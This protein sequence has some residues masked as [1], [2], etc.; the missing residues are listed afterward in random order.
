VSGPLAAVAFMLAL[1]AVE[2]PHRM[3]FATLDN[4]LSVG[5]ALV[6]TTDQQVTGRMDEV[7]LPRSN[8]VSRVLIDRESGAYFGYRLVAG[9]AGGGRVRIAFQSLPRGFDAE[10]KR[11]PPCEGCPALTRLTASDP[12]FPAPQ[13]TADGETVRLELLANPRSGERIIDVV[14]VSSRAVSAAEMQAAADRT[15]EA[16]R[17]GERG[18]VLVAR[19]AYPQ[20]LAE[21]QRALALTPDDAQLHNRLGACHQRMQQ[22][23]D[24]RRHYARALE[25]NPRHAEAWNNLGTLEHA[26]R[27]FKQAAQA[28]RKALDVRPAMAT[29]WTNLAAAQLAL[30]HVDEGLEAYRKAY[31][32]DPDTLDSRA[33]VVDSGLD[34]GMQ[35]FFVAKMLAAGGQAEAALGFLYKAQA[36]GFRDWRRVERDPDFRVLAADPRWRRLLREA[37]SP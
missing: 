19:G 13:V 6:R 26:Q 3:A 20:A 23:A 36:S 27:R 17:N 1:P 15:L 22:D 4:G 25:L 8:G 9:D 5:F 30:G 7:A 37:S 35:N 29:A 33:G 16:W 32:L 28:Y 11:R 18:R 12:R 34:P 2:P 24:A 14:K 21:F 10:I 31:Q